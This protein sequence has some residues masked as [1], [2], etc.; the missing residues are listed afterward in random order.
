MT[1]KISDF[2][3]RSTALWCPTQ[4]DFNA[5]LEEFERHNFELSSSILA[6]RYDRM[7]A[8]VMSTKRVYAEPIYYVDSYNHNFLLS[9]SYGIVEFNEGDT[10]N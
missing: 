4:A 6:Y 3:D 2:M 9:I 10:L 5:M 1:H 8:F 7:R